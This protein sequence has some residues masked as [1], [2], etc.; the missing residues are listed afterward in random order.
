MARPVAAS[1]RPFL[2]PDRGLMKI[3]YSNPPARRDH[4]TPSFGSFGL[5]MSTGSR[6]SVTL[7]SASEVDDTRSSSP[8]ALP[9]RP[10]E[11]SVGRDFVRSGPSCSM[12]WPTRA[13]KPWLPSR[14]IPIATAPEPTLPSSFRTLP[15]Q[16]GGHRPGRGSRPRDETS[17]GPG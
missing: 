4:H 15:G 11:C 3:R 8:A 9:E 6:L 7:S 10:P 12:M 2:N 17:L 14:L 1:R 5:S 16:R 13:N